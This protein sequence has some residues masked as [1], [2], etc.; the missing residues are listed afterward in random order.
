M[1]VKQYKMPGLLLLAITC[2]LTWGALCFGQDAKEESTEELAK[3][4]QN[5][6]A[7]LISIPFQSNFNF[8]QGPSNVTQYIMNVQPVIPISLNKDWNL[9]TRTIL[10]IINQPSIA[11]HAPN[12]FGLGDLNPTFFFSPAKSTGFIWGVGPTVTLPTATNSLLGGG[13][14]DAGPAAVALLIEGPWVVGALVNQQWSFAGWGQRDV[15]AMLIQPFINYN[16]SGGLYLTSA[17]IITA[18]WETASSQHRWTVPVGGGVGK[19]W[20]VGKVGLPVNTQL[21]A[22]YNLEHPNSAADWQ[23]RFQVQFLLPKKMFEK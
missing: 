14:W 2:G 15:S 20:R 23:L 9:I 7:D 21:Q 17:P 4:T 10:P 3:K 8:G 5:P 12:A 16:F 18:D 11:P 6:V 22:F 19:L 1:R 13:K